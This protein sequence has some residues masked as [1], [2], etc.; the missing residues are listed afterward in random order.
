MRSYQEVGNISRYRLDFFESNF[1]VAKSRVQDWTEQEEVDL[2][3][4]QLPMGWRIKVLQRKAKE[5]E[6]R[7][8]VKMMGKLMPG[9]KLS[10][11]LILDGGMAVKMAEWR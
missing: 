4:K 8:V 6:S 9:E 11:C 3:M 1:E 5:A 7:N 2:L 10:G